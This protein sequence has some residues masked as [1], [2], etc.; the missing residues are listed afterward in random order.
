MDLMDRLKTSR[1]F[2]VNSLSWKTIR[3]DVQRRF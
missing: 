2:K 1:V 3:D